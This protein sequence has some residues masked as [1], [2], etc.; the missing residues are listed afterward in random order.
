MA[1]IT[2]DIAH[3]FER[4]V[5]VKVLVNRGLDWMPFYEL[6]LQAM[7]R[8]G[9]TLSEQDVRFQLNYYGQAGYVESKTLR[10]GRADFELAVVR[11]T[12]KAV[13]LVEGRA[14]DPGVAL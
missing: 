2:K 8:L 4:G 1:E 7:S 10:A 5:I 12:A 13:D 11:A 14:A 6:R 3:E 9:C